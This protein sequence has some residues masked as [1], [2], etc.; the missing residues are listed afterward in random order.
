MYSGT[1]VMERVAVE[2]FDDFEID[3]ICEIDKQDAALA[4][5]LFDCP[6][7]GDIL[8]REW[9]KWASAPETLF[10]LSCSPCGPV[11]D[12]G[13]LLGPDD[14]DIAVTTS[15]WTDIV[16]HF[17]LKFVCGEQHHNL[18][19]KH[20]GAVLRAIDLGLARVGHQRTPLVPGAPMGIEECRDAKHA[21]LRRRI[22]LNSEADEVEEFIGPCPLL[23]PVE[24]P[25]AVLDDILEPDPPESLFVDGVIEHV[26]YA[27]PI[28]RQW[29]TVAA[30]LHVDASSPLFK[31]SRVT[32]H[33]ARECPYCRHIDHDHVYVLYSWRSAAVVVL[34]H[35]SRSKPVFHRGVPVSC[36]LHM[37]FSFDLLH[38]AGT[39]STMTAFGVPPVGPGKML[40]LVFHNGRWRAR[41][42]SSDEMFKLGGDMRGC[43]LYRIAV[44]GIS[45][46]SLCSK[47]G[48]SLLWNF[49]KAMLS[50][51]RRR[52][53][54]YVDAKALGVRIA[55]RP[56]SALQAFAGD[57]EAPGT[58]VV[59]VALSM[60]TPMVLVGSD[61]RSL[62][63]VPD[64]RAAVHRDAL[65]GVDALTGKFER[66]LG[67]VPEAWLA[68]QISRSSADKTF[69]AVCPLG[70][71]DV[72]NVVG[73]ELVWAS[74][75][76]G[77][78][79]RNAET[80]RVVALACAT[81]MTL[82]D[83]P[84]CHG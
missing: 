52:I 24:G 83:H 51:L 15:A 56:A 33:D 73:G 59:F 68:G 6:V 28:S 40:I 64:A 4:R 38:T 8:R 3:G 27:R 37:S 30:K 13:Q 45:E 66:E 79:T 76:D 41:R 16:A 60:G 35:D 69:V 22:C 63:T 82:L 14:P 32:L 18:A 21:G 65:Q 54:A 84:Q 67:Y 49:A 44:P 10:L 53:W 5:S 9:T 50:R 70:D 42:L 39:G 57:V 25:G 80:F 43:S 17:D 58:V 78:L 71:V 29:P 47:P 36:L 75:R 19:R 81:V 11:A 61:R 12:S 46:F 77:A 26:D 20:D 2:E 74:I 31:G 34:F 1:C 48:K 62:P 23:T 7:V 72:G 55:D